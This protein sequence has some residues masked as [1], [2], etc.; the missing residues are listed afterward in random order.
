MNDDDPS[1][2]ENAVRTSDEAIA[3]RNEQLLLDWGLAVTW[4]QYEYDND[5]TYTEPLGG[6]IEFAD[7]EQPWFFGIPDREGLGNELNW[8]RSG[9]QE[10]PGGSPPEE[11]V[12][13]D[14]KPGQP[15]DEGETWEGVLFGT[16]APYALV[17]WTEDITFSNGN[18]APY[19]VVA[20]TIKDLRWNNGP[21]TDAIPGTPNIDVVLTSD[22]SKWTRCPVFEMQPN[23]DLAQDMDTPLGSPEKMGLRRHASVDK[24]GKT[25]AQGGDQY[26]ATLNGQQPF[27][28]GWFPGYA[29]DVGTG[30]RLNM[31]F[32]EDS[33][34]SADNG[35]DMIWNPSSRV[36]GGLGNVYAGGQHWIYVFRN[37]AYSDDND[38]RCPAYDMGQYL[39]GK[40]GPNAGNNDDRKAM[41]G[42]GW[43]GS[44]LTN[45]E[46][47]MLSV[48]DGLIPTETRIKLRVAKQY[49]RYAYDRSDVD[50][51]ENTPNNNNPLYRFSTADVATITGDNPALTDALQNV[52]VV[53]NPYYAYSQYETSKLDNRVKITGLPE[54]CTIRIY[55]IAGT[56]VRTFDKA[57]PLTYVEWDLKNDRNV[58]IAGGVH[59][60]HVDAP[61]VGEKIVK[62]FAVMRP[63]DLENF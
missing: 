31:A 60:V 37:Q 58:P 52:R 11:A 56:L 13:D 51:V 27:G 1:N 12:F 16:W 41:R 4:E 63:V 14:F 62:W 36:A 39:Y 6:T 47:E 48:Q 3:I 46:F 43:V 15:Y 26:F 28:M 44:A 18:T 34:A 5:G 49:R 42:C 33:W 32:G 2:D 25:V 23:E 61:G 29:I 17:S 21:I 20:P 59:I 24:N 22:K 9:A 35:D 19:P 53:P 54:I 10:T 50:D 7:P 55:N 38:S 8:I 45:P 30:E 40:F 57:D